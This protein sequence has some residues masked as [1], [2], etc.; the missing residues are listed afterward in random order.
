[1]WINV[2]WEALMTISIQRK[3]AA[4]EAVAWGGGHSMIHFGFSA[5][6]HGTFSLGQLRAALTK[7]RQK[8]PI[9]GTRIYQADEHSLWCT[10]EGVPDFPIQ[11]LPRSS[12][13]DWKRAI[14][15]DFDNLF[16]IDSGPLVRFTLLQSADV[17]DL[18]MFYHH[19]LY[20]GLSAIYV[21]RDI[22]Y[23]LTHPD[24]PAQ[25]LVDIPD[26]YAL[27]PDS[28]IAEIAQNLPPHRVTSHLDRR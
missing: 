2:L 24:A 7:V 12:D 25:P 18:I 26:I 1:M 23:Y 14:E 28:I 17:S 13:E 22:L 5:R 16:P 9:L 27:I 21:L 10:S 3:L 19:A 8:Y 11:V 15:A 20:D 6:I 4:I